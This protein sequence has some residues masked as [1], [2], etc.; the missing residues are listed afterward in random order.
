[1][2]VK[3]PEID[4]GVDAGPIGNLLGLGRDP[5]AKAAP[6]ELYQW[7]GPTQ[8]QIDQ[9]R[10]QAMGQKAPRY[11]TGEAG[12]NY[13]SRATGVQAQQAYQTE[14]GQYYRDVLEGRRE[15]A[16]AQ[17]LKAG[18]EQALAAQLA[19]A[20]QAKGAGLAA[21]RYTAAQKGAEAQAQANQQAGIMRAQEQAQ[22]AGGYGTLLNQQQAANLAAFQA[23]QQS[24]QFRAE[25]AFKQNQLNQQM[26]LGY[27]TAGIAAGEAEGAL[28]VAQGQNF[29]TAQGVGNQQQQFASQQRTQLAGAGMS[30][31]AMASDIRAKE[32]IA[33]AGGN[34]APQAGDYSW[35][36]SQRQQQAPTPGQQGLARAL[37][38]G[39]RLAPG[40]VAS[41][42]PGSF[43]QEPQTLQALGPPGPN[44][45]PTL[46]ASLMTQR[47]RT[48][49]TPP[50]QAT[51]PIMQSAPAG[52]AMAPAPPPRPQL[53]P[54]ALAGPG[55][56]VASPRLSAALA[57]PQT[58]MS[59]PMTKMDIEPAGGQSHSKLMS[60]VQA[61]G[62]MQAG[63]IPQMPQ[64]SSTSIGD[65]I[66]AGAKMGQQIG[67][68]Q[69]ADAAA[70][71]QSTVGTQEWA[72][73][74]SAQPLPSQPTPTTTSNAP[75]WLNQ[76]MVGQGLATPG[77]QYVP[78]A[79]PAVAPATAGAS[80]VIPSDRRIKDVEV[81]GGHTLADDFLAALTRSAS[82]YSYKN[83]A[84]EPTDTPTGGK[85]LGVMAQ[86]V[87]KTP[88]GNTIVKEGPKGMYLEMGP[89]L[90]AALA[91]LGRLNERLDVIEEALG[92]KKSKK[93]G[94]K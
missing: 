11:E 48:S 53:A 54:E 9:R 4:R 51:P 69:A 41:S 71:Q 42:A 74:T 26:G 16:G 43:M 90:S 36:G 77:P 82:T 33:P 17:Q 89:S 2:V 55:P 52:A 75:A 58:M 19:A 49:R 24:D 86:E 34:P 93:K 46:P 56:G 22:A 66:M 78:A 38:G 8:Y 21:A 94:K 10:E 62:G 13:M 84:D 72:Q 5:Q 18:G 80:P 1:M 50:T 85:Y 3:N 91:G 27:T 76:Y 20:H 6:E 88:T 47:A 70:K 30:A 79:A 61:S 7:Q 28:G 92:A 14:L 57:A 65:S 15:S 81:P 87:A 83:P 67:A 23:M 29:L 25:L 39:P 37:S 59:D 64:G 35:G 73:A 63:V 40:T 31:A 45:N 32:N 60:S 44:A 68:K 12:S